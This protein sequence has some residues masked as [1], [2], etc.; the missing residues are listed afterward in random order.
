MIDVIEL[1]ILY[2]CSFFLKIVFY[3]LFYCCLFCFLNCCLLICIY[4]GN[5]IYERMVFNVFGYMVNLDRWRI[6][7]NDS[8]VYDF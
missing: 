6:V 3:L 5:L 4:L 1:F 2:I 8:L 7:L